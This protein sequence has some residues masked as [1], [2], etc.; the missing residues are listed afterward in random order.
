[1][2][3]RTLSTFVRLFAGLQRG[4]YKQFEY[5]RVTVPVTG[6][7]GVRNPLLQDLAA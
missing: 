6:T 5:G 3:H 2:N 4:E 7:I 1:M